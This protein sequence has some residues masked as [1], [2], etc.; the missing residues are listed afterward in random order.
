MSAL[1]PASSTIR[2]LA[3]DVLRS[4]KAFEPDGV[5][6]FQ[7]LYKTFEGKSAP[8]EVVSE[9]R[10]LVDA[11]NAPSISNRIYN[12][13]VGRNSINPEIDPFGTAL[14]QIERGTA[15]PINMLQDFAKLW[16]ESA[17]L[18]KRRALAKGRVMYG[19]SQGAS[20]NI[21]LSNMQKSRYEA[22]R[23]RSEAQMYEAL[24]SLFGESL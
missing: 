13:R 17:E 12:R 9:F 11:L 24:R 6:H 7:K 20:G 16:D 10:R 21:D 4:G 22:T 23:E 1:L 14:D 19:P 8:D 18:E 15:P 3:L 5:K 2:K